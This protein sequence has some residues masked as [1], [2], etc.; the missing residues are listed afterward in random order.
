MEKDFE[1]NRQR[2]IEQRDQF[3]E[4][5][6]DVPE[7]DVPEIAPQYGQRRSPRE[8][9]RR[10]L[11]EERSRREEE[12]AYREAIKALGDLSRAGVESSRSLRATTQSA[13][14]LERQL[15]DLRS[16]FQSMS[17]DMRG[18]SDSMSSSQKEIRSFASE[19]GRVAQGLRLSLAATTTELRNFRRNLRRSADYFLSLPAKTVEKLNI[20]LA[21]L[22]TVVKDSFKEAV[23]SLKPELA[24]IQP[25]IIIPGQDVLI[26]EVRKV[27]E[28]V[29]RSKVE[30]QLRDLSAMSREMSEEEATRA[31]KLRQELEKLSKKLAERREYMEKRPA[32]LTFGRGLLMAPRALAVTGIE[33]VKVAFKTLVSEMTDALLASF[34]PIG[35][36]FRGLFDQ[37][38]WTYGM[39]RTG[40]SPRRGFRGRRRIADR[41][42]IDE[43]ELEGRYEARRASSLPRRLAALRPPPHTPRAEEFSPQRLRE[44]ATTPGPLSTGTIVPWGRRRRGRE[45]WEEEIEEEPRGVMGIF[46]PTLFATQVAGSLEE[47][48]IEKAQLRIKQSEI[49]QDRDAKITAKTLRIEARGVEIEGA[50]VGRSLTDKIIDILGIRA[51]LKRGKVPEVPIP[52]RIPAPGKF[53][54]ILG[55]VGKRLPYVGAALAGMEALI[56]G[57][58]LA[59]AAVRGGSTLAGGAIGFAIAGPIGAVL[60]GIL[61][62][63]ISEH[64]IEP[65]LPKIS[66]FA[67]AVYEGMKKVLK[68]Q[69]W[70]NSLTNAFET[71][72]KAVKDFFSS[73]WSGIRKAVET[74]GEVLSDIQRALSDVVK[75]AFGW[76]S[77]GVSKIG[78]K[79]KDAVDIARDT[80]GE[81]ADYIDRSAK[82]LTS[83]IQ[84]EVSAKVTPI[85]QQV[86]KARE[87]IEGGPGAVMARFETGLGST[88]KSLQE[89]AA[90]ISEIGGIIGYGIPQFTPESA[91]EFLKRSGF[92]HYFKGVIPG[93]AEFAKRWKEV[94]TDPRVGKA[95]AEAQ[96]G[97]VRRY[98]L[99]PAAE[100][101]KEHWGI[102]VE[103]SQTL[104][105]MLL[106]R[107]V[108]LG[109]QGVV[110]LIG[111]ALR[112]MTREEVKQLDE[113]ELIRRIYETQKEMLPRFFRT[114]LS[115]EGEKL[116]KSLE[117]RIEQEK[118]AVL[119]LA[120]ATEKM[121]TSAQTLADIPHY[122]PPPLSPPKQ[123]IEMQIPEVLT[124]QLPDFSALRSSFEGMGEEVIAPPTFD[125]YPEDLLREEM[126]RRERLARG[127]AERRRVEAES[128]A[129]IMAGRWRPEALAEGGRGF[130]FPMIAGEEFGRVPLMIDDI[131]ILMLQLGLN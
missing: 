124:E 121:V 59:K 22:S 11:E 69:E 24:S 28:A 98:F 63:V 110:K 115:R 78:E 47:L 88:A 34:G 111:Q 126:A 35:Q 80:V 93:T 97:Y 72:W 85:V 65:A 48:D 27:R 82:T 53:G 104:Q 123:A 120:G 32:W 86:Q 5:E 67:T 49:K 51:L 112:G 19:V 30:E 41:R 56:G 90:K 31:E 83:T 108:H 94:A 18:I 39:G 106:A 64:L 60:G 6:G 130:A 3:Y 20:D 74:V 1:A 87:L 54:R 38:L 89:A 73:L 13:S 128:V 118:E 50:E 96:L 40:W 33:M 101:V 15:Q 36:I 37:L 10:R 52:G 16:L 92:E 122:E 103:K 114:V 57:E 81:V 119:H 75:R 117:T 8:G 71:G 76:I 116:R 23:E 107:A 131:G 44:M 25:Q 77:E 95:F 68:T 21:N 102:E 129:E 109:P 125:Y 61:G 45:R 9:F 43:T 113:K 42:R 105:E 55:L 84:K 66:E 4:R 79:V 70:F 26:T 58:G 127:E 100:Y 12:R 46:S 99:A 2:L 14:Q 7:G 91:R 62:D 17:E 29:S